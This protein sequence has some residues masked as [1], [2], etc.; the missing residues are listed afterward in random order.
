MKRAVLTASFLLLISTAQAQSPLPVTVDNFARAESDLYLGN[1]VKDAG[2]TG[3]LS[4]HREPIQVDKQAVI[5]SNRDTLYS[6]LVLDLDAGPATITLPDAGKRFRSMQVINEDHYVVGKV[7]YGAG[8]YTLD[9]DK[10]GTRYVLVA[11]RTLVDPNDPKDVEKVHAIQDAIK[12]SQKA[13]GKFEIP[14]WDAASQKKVRDALLVLSSTTAGFKNA[15]GAKGQVDPIRHLIA[16]AAGWGGNPDK[17][18]TYLSVTPEKND[19]NTVYKLT[20]P[21]NVPVDGFWSISL[22][23]AEGYF[24]KNPY[25]AYSLNNLTATKSA[26]GSTTV[27]FGGCDGKIPNCLPI[28]KGWNYTVRLYRPRPEI[29]NGKWKFPEPKPVS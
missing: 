9:R 3:R 5:R 2:G 11:L 13:P 19:G 25:N 20:V 12:V 18:A 24:E 4:H 17:D 6:A 1:G 14:N 16:T 26:D 21:G 29:L 10:A 8:S 7:E 27:Q 23:N 28:M 22:Y 15:F